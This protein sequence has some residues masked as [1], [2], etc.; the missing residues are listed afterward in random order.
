MNKRLNDF[1]GEALNE[2]PDLLDEANSLAGNFSDGML[3]FLDQ[4]KVDGALLSQMQKDWRKN[5]V[6][7]LENFIIHLIIC[8]RKQEEIL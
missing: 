4:Q 2:H 8:V 1:L 5:G 7:I 3:P 6:V